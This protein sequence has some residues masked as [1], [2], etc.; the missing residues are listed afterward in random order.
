MQTGH[1]DLLPSMV[2]AARQALA[3]LGVFALAYLGSGYYFYLDS[4]SHRQLGYYAGQEA[5]LTSEIIMAAESFALAA[6]S[7][8][9]AVNSGMAIKRKRFWA[10]PSEY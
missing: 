6:R 3:A 5:L 7:G 4:A 8:G 9:S 10:S 2:R 1:L